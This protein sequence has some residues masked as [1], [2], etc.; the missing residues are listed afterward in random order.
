VKETFFGPQITNF[1]SVIFRP[2][3]HFYCPISLSGEVRLITSTGNGV[4]IFLGNEAARMKTGNRHG[5]G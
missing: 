2:Q 4:E 3:Y 1:L 5:K